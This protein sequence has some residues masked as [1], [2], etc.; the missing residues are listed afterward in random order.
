MQTSDARPQ[1]SVSLVVPVFNGAGNLEELV[2]RSGAVLAEC[3]SEHEIIFVNDGSVDESWGTIDRLSHA[4]VSVRG[5][6]LCRNYGQHNALLAGIRAARHE[7]TVT[8][9]DDLQNPP[10]EIPK[11]LGALTADCDVVYGVP[12]ATQQNFGRR[13]ARGVVVRALRVLGGKTA[14]LVSAF[15]ALRTDLRDGFADYSGPDV[16]IDGLLTWRT[17]RFCSVP[18]R[19]DPRANGKS[20]YSLTKLVRHALTMITAFS[21]RPLRIATTLGFFV[22]FFGAIVLVYV[23]VRFLVEGGSVPGFP[24]LASIISIFSGAQ[25]FGIGV[26]GEYLARMHV[27]VMARPSYAIR[28]TAEGWVGHGDAPGPLEEQLEGLCRMLD[29]DSEFWGFPIAR[30]VPDCLDPAV[31]GRVADWCAHNRIHCAYLLASAGDAETARAAEGVGFKLVDTRIELVRPAA[32][33]TIDVSQAVAV[34]PAE[35]GDEAGVAAIARSAHTDSRF[36]FDP[37]F[38]RARAGEL[39]ATWVRKGFGGGTDDLLVAEYDGKVSG[40]VLLGDRAKI[41]LIGVS[42]AA[43]GHGVGRALV[44]SA[45]AA[46]GDR[47]V[48]VVTQARNV[49]AMRLYEASG[50]K[51]VSADAWYHRWS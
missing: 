15:R 23:L 46:D 31:A 20:N 26:I 24:F 43:R 2:Q 30:V 22:T 4:G 8:I 44:L 51:V 49:A 38:D 12:I 39:Y 50:F 40:Y 19:H 21:T 7:I 9:D 41:E 10:E 27:R 34:R 16:S 28:A 37:G 47:D 13:M 17:E 1:P 36:F 33:G 45:I 48:K 32:A 6:D 3:A 42:D 25:L 11:L 29:W 5:I 14:P 18:V 35:A